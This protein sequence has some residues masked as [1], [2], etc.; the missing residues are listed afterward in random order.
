MAAFAKAAPAAIPRVQVGEIVPRGQDF[1]TV[2]HLYRSIE[3]GVAHLAE[4]LGE[5]VLFI[6]PPRAQATQQYF[7]WPE[8]VAVTDVASAQRA[9]DEILE[10]GEGP[11]GHW[12]DAHFGQFVAILEEY[13]QLREANPAFD[14][15]RPW[16][17]STS[18][19]PSATPAFRWPPT[20][21]PAR[22]WTCST[23]ATRSCC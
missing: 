11:R 23:S 4:K 6:G 8:L 14:P 19:R 13:L 7:G 2:G 17:R 15:V 16:S 20:R 22:S 3:A 1:A 18:G 12:K 9:I 21:S 10:Q 5:Q